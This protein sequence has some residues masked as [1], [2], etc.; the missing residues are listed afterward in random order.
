LQ[1]KASGM[2]L[3]QLEISSFLQGMY[4]FRNLTPTEL[5]QFANLFHIIELQKGQVLHKINDPARHL[6]LCEYGSIE[7]LRLSDNNQT[8][9]FGVVDLCEF[10]GLEALIGGQSYETQAVALNQSTVLSIE[11]DDLFPLLDQFPEINQFLQILFN[12][13]Y[14]LLGMRLS[15]RQED[16]MVFWTSRKHPIF[17]WLRLMIPILADFIILAMYIVLLI[18]DIINPISL[19][20]I[21]G[22]L[23]AI[24]ILPIGYI[25][26]DWT[27]DFFVIT[28]RR[29]ISRKRVILLYETK[30]E[31]TLDAIQS[32][33]KKI[34]SFWG[35]LGGFGD[36][37]IR[38]FTGFIIF[39]KIPNPDIINEFIEDVRS[40]RK[41]LHNVM[42]REEKLTEMR[43]KLGYANPPDNNPQIPPPEIEP[44]NLNEGGFFA[45]FNSIFQALFRLRSVNGDEVTYRTHWLI[46]M[47][48]AFFPFLIFIT[49]SLLFIVLLVRSSLLILAGLPIFVNVI[50]AV[51]GFATF[52]ISI[53]QYVDWRNDRYIVNNRQIVDLDQKPFGREDRRTAPLSSVQSVEYKRIGFFSIILNFGTV[54][55]RVGDTLLT[56]DYVANPSAVQQEIAQRI[57]IARERERQNEIRRERE[58]ILDWIDVYHTV[59]HAP[60]HPAS[61]DS[62]LPISPAS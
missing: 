60:V 7:L 3:T 43:R 59:V 16:E 47:K 10:F 48:K 50:I 27:D 31:T 8:E 4:P 19:S 58:A 18:S 23:I 35:A 44:A 34:N 46:L 61:P 25:Y 28:D 13:Y 39:D 56:F 53:Y 51:V 36:V 30:E 49:S 15:W 42:D 17:L 33:T 52:L 5:A 14:P 45:A 2:S 38:T 41:R 55:I 37:I 32:V 21:F 20:I 1:K 9:R 29:V 6:Y 22:I 40:R 24:I 57:E 62:N 54:F 12:S 11:Q 26:V